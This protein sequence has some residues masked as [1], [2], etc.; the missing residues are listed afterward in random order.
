MAI[1]ISR[2]RIRQ[3]EHKFQ[4]GIFRHAR[5]PDGRAN[6][7]PLDQGRYNSRFLFNC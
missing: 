3:I 4:D 1:V 5:Q 7:I 6:R 2:A